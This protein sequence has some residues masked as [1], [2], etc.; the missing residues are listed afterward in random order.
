M[1]HPFTFRPGTVDEQIFDVVV[2]YNDYRLPERFA[3][4]DIV[5]DIGT[6]IGS[7]CYA[8]LQRGARHVYGFEPEASNYEC[9]VRNLRS[10]GDRVHLYNKAVWRSDQVVEKLFFV[11]SADAANTSGGGV[12]WPDA[13]TP[14]DVVT[15]DDVIR[16]VTD[17]GNKRIKLLKIDCEGAE[18]PILLTSRMLLVIDNIHGEFHEAGGDY[19]NAIIPERA[20][21][22]GFPRFTIDKL[23]GVLQQAGFR[24]ISIR[25]D[26]SH[27]GLFFAT[28]NALPLNGYKNLDVT[29]IFTV[30]PGTVDET[31]FKN[32]NF[33]NE[34]RLPDKFSMDDVIVDI[35]THVG[36]FCYAVLQ[37]GAGSVYGFEPDIEN[38]QLA[39]INLQEFG[40]RIRLYN[41]AVWRSDKTTPQIMLARI[42]DN[43]AGGSILWANADD[44]KMK[45]NVGVVAFDDMLWNITNGAQKRVRLLK[46]DCEASEFP[47]LLTSR[48]LHLID[49][50]RGE[51]HEL[52]GEYDNILIP[53]HFR[54]PGFDRFTI[55]E[56]TDVLRGAG[57]AVSSSR[58]D[59]S[60]IGFF[61]AS[62]ESGTRTTP[63]PVYIDLRNIRASHHSFA[64]AFHRH[65]LEVVARLFRRYIRVGSQILSVSFEQE[66]LSKLNSSCHPY[67]LT[68]LDGDRSRLMEPALE[69]HPGYNWLSGNIQWLPFADASFDAV[70]AGQVIEQVPDGDAALA[71]WTRVLRPGGTLIITTPNRLRLL[72]RLNHT[73]VPVS[74][75]HLVE[76]TCEEL[77]A[78]FER[79]G[80]DVLRRE[81]IYLELLSLWR[82]RPPYVDPLTAPQPLRRH[83][84]AL[85]PLMMLARPLPWLAWD[86]VFV[87]TKCS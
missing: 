13:G 58:Q 16:D 57:F 53:E 61:F 43:T 82:Q 40:E 51:F 72:N 42:D 33:H 24:V 46:I 64:Q 59:Q 65:R 80:C 36:S 26:S 21:V 73:T 76:F 1:S 81:G 22:A 10:F 78:M 18:F 49:E 68:W 17:G 79:N 69:H 11:G 8:V 52:G 50:V 19:E 28:R 9:A 25:H 31:I 15:L 44:T 84:L 4:D 2:T 39:R 60:N 70:Y 54:V 12:V 71:E 20:R 23:T 7:F 63:L 83:T 67:R 74:P 35:G 87:G 55:L 29:P 45:S 34:Y 62:R 77:T 48:M 85:K 41:Q 5:V 3:A 75:E 86:M 32:I 27:M 30:R 14:V 37:R 47:I 66:L 38:Y 56:L 6:H